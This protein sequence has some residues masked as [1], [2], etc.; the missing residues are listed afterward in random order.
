MQ[1]DRLTAARMQEETQAVRDGQK[2]PDS[3]LFRVK[4]GRGTSR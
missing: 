3:K 1:T 2:A 4:P